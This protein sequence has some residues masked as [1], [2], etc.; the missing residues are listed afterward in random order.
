M[1]C[2]LW[3]LSI[4][5]RIYRPVHRFSYLRQEHGLAWP[6]EGH[7]A[8]APIPASMNQSTGPSFR[9]SIHIRSAGL[10]GP[11]GVAE[12]AQRLLVVDVGRGQRADHDGLGVAA[13]RVL[14]A[15]DAGV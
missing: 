11:V 9:L 5:L 12:G 10:L 14:R 8:L 6:L 15:R 3:H 13:Q 4:R 7:Y 2:M 1:A